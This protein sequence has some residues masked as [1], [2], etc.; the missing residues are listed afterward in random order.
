M[1]IGDRVQVRTKRHNLFRWDVKLE[2][3]RMFPFA[4]SELDLMEQ[5]GEVSE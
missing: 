2:N 3:G 5:A 1:N 4:E